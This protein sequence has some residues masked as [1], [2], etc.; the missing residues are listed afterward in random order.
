MQNP[1]WLI[2]DF[3]PDNNFGNLA[4]EAKNQGAYVRLEQCMYSSDKLNFFSEDDIVLSQTSIGLALRIQKETNWKP[5]PWLTIDNYECVN[6]YP[7][8]KNAGIPLYNGNGEFFT[9]LEVERHIDRIV[10]QYGEKSTKRVFIRPSSG[11][12]PFT[13]M[14]F[15]AR[16]DLFP[17]DWY[18][19]NAGCKDTDM[20]LVAKPFGH[21]DRIVNEWRFIAAEGEIIEGSQYY[22]SKYERTWPE[23]AYEM[24]VECANAYQPDPMY[25]VD[26]VKTANDQYYVMEV[27]SFSC[28]GLYGCDL[29]PV[30]ERAIDIAQNRG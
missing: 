13:G 16:P 30:V 23:E 27:N 7:I 1:K 14:V 5:G 4:Q 25:T 6:Y 19:V 20:L 24:A 12:K 21:E 8:L 15:I 22:N 28:A 10:E 29:R 11:L 9:K 2:E 3:A 18:W 26:I 17:S